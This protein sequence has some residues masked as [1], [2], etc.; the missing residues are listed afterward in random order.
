MV[1]KTFINSKEWPRRGNWSNQL[2]YKWQQAV[3]W[4]QVCPNAIHDV[5]L[6]SEFWEIYSLFI[7]FCL[8]PCGLSSKFLS[9]IVEDRLTKM[10]L[11]IWTSALWLLLKT[12]FPKQWYW[13]I[14]AIGLGKNSIWSFSNNISKCNT[15][16]YKRPR[17]ILTSDFKLKLSFLLRICNFLCQFIKF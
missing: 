10:L 16:L 9:P 11:L 8:C 12:I 17:Q 2:V 14:T 7:L 1:L 13:R 6:K 3:E 4:L 15:V 5:V